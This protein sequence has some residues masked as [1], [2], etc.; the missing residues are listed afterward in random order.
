MLVSWIDEPLGEN[1]Q[2]WNEHEQVQ[3]PQVAESPPTARI[4]ERGRQDHVL[5]S[6]WG[7]HGVGG[8]NGSEYN[9]RAIDS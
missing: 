4:D 8:N 1:G 3:S 7:R 6:V 9:V 5:G 2:Q